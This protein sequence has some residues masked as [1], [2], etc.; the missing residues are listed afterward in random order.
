MGQT[1]ASVVTRVYSEEGNLFS[2]W[3]RA[4]VVVLLS[5]TRFAKDIIFMGDPKKT[6]KAL[7]EVLLQCSQ[8]LSYMCRLLETLTETSA[9]NTDS[10]VTDPVIIEHDIHPFRPIDVALPKNDSGCCYILVSVRHLSVTYIGQTNNL[11]ERL[12]QHN[13]GHGSNQTMADNLRPWALLGY[14]VGFD[15]NRRQQLA[16]EAQWKA[17]RVRKQR[18]LMRRLTANEVA[19]LA[20][21]V[22]Q[23][24]KTGYHSEILRFVRAGNI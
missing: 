18:Q 12:N 17:S 9:V 8:Y 6:A 21:G 16:F 1:L 19:D 22:I 3:E 2:L 5:R 15:S 23:A 7:T 11:S 4:Q 10:S 13:S 14:V 24:R 20:I